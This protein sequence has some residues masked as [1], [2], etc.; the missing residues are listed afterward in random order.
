MN[1]ANNLPG[2]ILTYSS[3]LP[4]I[5][6]F[7]ILCLN[8][9][10]VSLIKKVALNF[11]FAPLLFYLTLLGSFKSSS[12]T[13]QFVYS[14]F[15]I[16]SL[17]LNLT[18]GVDGISI[19]FVLLTTLLIPLCLLTSWTSVGSHMK[20]YFIFFLIIEFLLINAFC[21]L[22]ILFFYIFFESVLIPMFLIIGI[23]GSRERKVLASLISCSN[24]RSDNLLTFDD[25]FSG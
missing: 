5:G 10:R 18:I 6:V 25:I 17:N 23:W 20:E 3:F 12:G 15:W 13:F 2:V 16:P 9:S 14:T 11:S 21:S 24:S 8:K 19:F 1:Y 4:L 22:D 7:A